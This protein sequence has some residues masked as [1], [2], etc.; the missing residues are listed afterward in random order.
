MIGKLWRSPLWFKILLAM[1]LGSVL[2]LMSPAIA[3]LIKPLGVMFI[4]MIKM[5]IVPLVFFSITS[6][7]MSMDSTEKLGPKGIKAIILYL[8]TTACAIAI[9]LI[10]GHVMRPGDNVTLAFD[11][12]SN[13]HTEAHKIHWQNTFINLIPENIVDAFASNNVLQII[14]FAIVLAIATRMAG[15]KAE[16][17]ITLCCSAAEV[18]YKVTAIMIRF[19]PMGVFSLMASLVASH[20]I[21]ILHGLLQVVATV[22]LS[23][24]VHMLLIY[25]GMLYL[26]TKLNPLYFLSKIIPAQ[27][28]AFSTSSS[29]A[30]LPITMQVAEKKLGVSKTTSS[31]V[32]PIGTTVNMDGTALYQ[33]VCVMFA[34]QALG[35]DLTV[36]Q[37]ITVILTSTL[38]SIGTAG[39]PGAGLIM[40]SLVLSSIGLPLEIVA[41]IAGIDRILDMVRTLVNITGDVMVALV[42]DSYEQRLNKKIYYSRQYSEI[43]EA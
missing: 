26:L 12:A 41:L 6:A 7:I 43:E 9:G 16:P 19:T 2:G 20:D 24:A 23:S 18:M 22:Y 14:V 13:V 27:L 11:A 15:K 30:T 31:F 25:G 37:Y 10:I 3:E 28:M 39:V 42:V 34:A 40:L 5:L 21:N 17:V 33:G 29:T 35:V 8:I 36:G 1:A 32:L 4:R 38:A